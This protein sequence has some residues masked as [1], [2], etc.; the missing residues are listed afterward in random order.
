MEKVNVNIQKR[1]AMGGGASNGIYG[2][3]FIGA[4]VYYMQHAA[5]F[6]DGVL[7]FLKALVW[8]AM[9]IYK[10]LEYLKM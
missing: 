1:R 7:G 5:T 4:L 9:F 10:A 8:P 3:A 6:G 2:L